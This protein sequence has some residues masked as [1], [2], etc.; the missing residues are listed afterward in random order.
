MDPSFFRAVGTLLTN[1]KLEER[2]RPP[3]NSPRYRIKEIFYTQKGRVP[4]ELS[5]YP[6]DNGRPYINIKAFEQNVIENYV[7]SED[8]VTVTQGDLVIVWDGARCGLVGQGKDGVLCST[9]KKLTVKDPF[10]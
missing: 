9:L 1:E 6:R 3:S 7:V 2:L 5:R 8:G 10:F 4:Q